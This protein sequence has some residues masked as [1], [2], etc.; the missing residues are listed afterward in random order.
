MK[1]VLIEGVGW[2]E[3]GEWPARFKHE[4]K[5]KRVFK[6]KEVCEAKGDGTFHHP[7]QAKP[8]KPVKP[9]PKST[10]LDAAIKQIET[11][12]VKSKHKHA[13]KNFKRPSLEPKAF[14]VFSRA[15]R[16]G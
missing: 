7:K 11:G 3:V 14:F 1:T 9:V 13:A 4:E 5:P 15:R 16:E 2:P 12:D 6:R 8:R 10:A